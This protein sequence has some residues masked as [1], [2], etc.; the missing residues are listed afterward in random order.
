LTSVPCGSFSTSAAMN[1]PVA[2]AAAAGAG[3][4][5]AA[6]AGGAPCSDDTSLGDGDG[7]GCRNAAGAAAASSSSPPPAAA[8]PPP[9]SST[10][11]HGVMLP[12]PASVMLARNSKVTM[13]RAVASSS[14]A[15]SAA[16]NVTL[17]GGTE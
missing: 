17:D 3:A 6:A 9:R 14:S 7:D 16:R 4:G 2:A 13:S 15:P 8:P 1:E 10:N 5:S 12:V 11:T